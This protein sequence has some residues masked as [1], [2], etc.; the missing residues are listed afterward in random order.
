MQ[1]VLL[2]QSDREDDEPRFILLAFIERMRD[3]IRFPASTAGLSPAP[4]G[5]A[6]GGFG[7]A[8]WRIPMTQG[9]VAFSMGY[10]LLSAF[11]IRAS[12]WSRARNTLA[13]SNIRQRVLREP[14]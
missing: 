8:E 12:S 14:A 5:F 7:S 3:R 6:R 11:V 9:V 13:T 4:R 2:S 1:P 10:S